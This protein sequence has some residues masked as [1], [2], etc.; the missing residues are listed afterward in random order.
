MHED[1]WK[2]SGRIDEEDLWYL[3]HDLVSLK[4]ARQQYNIG[5][6]LLLRMAKHSGAMYKIGKSVR[7]DRARFEAYMRQMAG[8]EEKKKAKKEEKHVE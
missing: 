5:E 8:L 3:S 7:L 2:Y 1:I 4:E 6:K